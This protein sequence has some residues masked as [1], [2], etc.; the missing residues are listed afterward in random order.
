MKNLRNL[1]KSRK[2]SKI[3]RR[4]CLYI[5][6]AKVGFDA[7]AMHRSASTTKVPPE[8]TQNKNPDGGKASE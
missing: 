3:V 5:I 1:Q 4:H 7:A 6:K 2:I 8:N